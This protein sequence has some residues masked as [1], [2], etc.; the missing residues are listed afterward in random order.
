MLGA[1][2]RR[3]K[4]SINILPAYSMNA[5]AFALWAPKRVGPFNNCDGRRH[6]MLYHYDCGIRE[7]FVPGISSGE[8]FLISSKQSAIEL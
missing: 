6:A 7:I 5:H 8:L 2:W 1:R 4:L 3:R